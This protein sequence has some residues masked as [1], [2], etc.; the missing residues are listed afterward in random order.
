MRGLWSGNQRLEAGFLS[1]SMLLFVFMAPLT[2][3]LAKDVPGGPDTPVSS[4]G[5]MPAA[6]APADAGSPFPSGSPE[7]ARISAGSLGTEASQTGSQ[8]KKR[9]PV[10]HE[11]ESKDRLF[12]DATLIAVA[13]ILC[14]IAFFLFISLPKQTKKT[15]SE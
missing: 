13:I 11:Q 4:D 9:P 5:E 6:S 3:A 12:V 15:G 7:P 2:G 14:V 8:V 10:S 1:L